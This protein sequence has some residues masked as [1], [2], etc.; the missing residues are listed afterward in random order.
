MSAFG[1]RAD[2][3]ALGLLGWRRMRRAL[4]ASNDRIAVGI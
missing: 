2:I 4:T 3:D 1:V